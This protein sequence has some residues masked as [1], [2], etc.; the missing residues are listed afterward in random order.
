M[1][2]TINILRERVEKA[3]I[4]MATLVFEVFMELS[5]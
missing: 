4:F 3:I 5:I 2:S 1:C